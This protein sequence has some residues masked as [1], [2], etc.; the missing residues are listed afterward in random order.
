MPD[1]HAG[2][3]QGGRRRSAKWYILATISVVLTVTVALAAIV[4]MQQEYGAA[5]A[6]LQVRAGITA[7]LQAAALAQPL[8]VFDQPQ[9]ERLVEALV[10]DPDFR[11]VV[12]SD[13]QGK[14]IGTR[15]QP[16]L[17]GRDVVVH[18]PVIFRDENGAE[19]KLGQLSFALSTDRLAAEL[20]TKIL[21]T[22]AMLAVMLA[23]VMVG[24]RQVLNTLVLTPLEKLTDALESLADGKV[25]APIPADLK[26][27]EIAALGHVLA[28]FRANKQ[29]ADALSV[30]HAK[31]LEV[32]L[33]RRQTIETLVQGFDQRPRRLAG[34][35][36]RVAT[37]LIRIA[38]AMAETA[39]ETGRQS[40][41]VT[42]AAE[43]ASRNV[44]SVASAAEQLSAS[45]QEI[46][47][48][49]TEAHD[50][51][52][53]A[54]EQAEITF[55]A[56]NGLHDAA[57]RIGEVVGLINDIASQTNLL[58]LNATIEAARAGEAGKGF[59][60]VA[61][62]VKALAT[63]TARATGDIRQQVDAIQSATKS[64]VDAISGVR[65]TVTK[66]NE[67][68]SIIASA[69]EEQRAATAEIARNSV[70]AA[71]RSGEV[72]SASSAVRS[73][74]A[75]GENSAA[76]IY[77]SSQGLVRNVEMLVGEMEQFFGDLKTA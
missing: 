45:I 74:A 21:G 33:R 29:E 75:I 31:A 14:P 70:E 51:N 17:D 50:I 71:E 18:A 59:A 69:V 76:T 6:S 8:W 32:E 23:V 26:V 58:A 24:I 56:V 54:G 67:V 19:N 41:E 13:P 60:V 48:I 12:L 63:Q 46:G 57:S 66:L 15:G 68:N 25:D 20:R 16:A 10:A 22:V 3:P 1:D 40:T 65:D 44:E 37:E 34:E 4:Q 64:V 7:R 11:G 27:R 35:L 38:S 28:V 62:E 49:V 36:S 2:R 61:N 9:T 77:S 72:N 52:L 42:S 43:Q 47:R 5:R 73:A 30:E 55:S 53:G 39:Q